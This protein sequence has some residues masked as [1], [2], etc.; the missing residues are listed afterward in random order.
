M[1]IGKFVKKR[2]VFAIIILYIG[3]SFSGG[4]ANDA[5]DNLIFIHHSCGSNWLSNSLHGALLAKDYIDERNDITY[6]T[7]VL[8][9]AGRPDSLAPNPG[10]NTNMNHWILWFNDYLD[11]V[12]SHDYTDGANIIIMF[13]SCYPLSNIG[14][15]GTEPGDPFDPQRTLSNYKAI[16]RHPDGPGNTYIHNSYEYMPLEDIFAN[17]PDTL[18]IPVTAPPRHY[19]PSDATND[20]E[21]HRAHQFNN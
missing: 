2:L 1:I 5:D 9:D 14:S 15:D 11:G 18:F 8:P 12:I 7:D 3:V 16:Y 19:A 10:D 20:A 17:N 4:I 21:G 6:D 13:K